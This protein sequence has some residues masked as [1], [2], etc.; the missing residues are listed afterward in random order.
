MA[1]V[2]PVFGLLILTVEW[3]VLRR[4]TGRLAGRS[5]GVRVLAGAAA[6]LGMSAAIALLGLLVA[7]V[8]T[9][10]GVTADAYNVAAAVASTLFLT[11]LL[12][13]P[14]A[15]AFGAI[16]LGVERYRVAP[17]GQEGK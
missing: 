1:A 2:W 15:A 13:I 4:V 3:V 10:L 12:F 5:V 9:Q 7:L 17:E 6:G 14:V 8:A 11:G 16:L